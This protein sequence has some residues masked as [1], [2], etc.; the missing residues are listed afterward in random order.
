MLFQVLIRIQ[1]SRTKKQDIR[2]GEY[3]A[4]QS[5][6]DKVTGYVKPNKGT[7]YKRLNKLIDT[8]RMEYLEQASKDASDSQSMVKSKDDILV[9][10]E[11]MINNLDKEGKENSR[12]LFFNVKNHIVEVLY[13]TDRPLKL[14]LEDID[15]IFLD[16]FKIHLVSKGLAVSTIKGYMDKITTIF[17][18]INKRQKHLILNPIKDYKRKIKNVETKISFHSDTFYQ[19][20]YYLPKSKERIHYKNWN[21][22][23][24]FSQ[25]QRISDIIITDWTSISFVN[26]NVKDSMKNKGKVEKNKVRYHFNAFKTGTEHDM[27]LCNQAILALRFY[28]DRDLQLQYLVDSENGIDED[29]ELQYYMKLIELPSER[30]LHGLGDIQD[31][32]DVLIPLI[33]IQKLRTPKKCIFHDVYTEKLTH[34]EKVK[35]ITNKSTCLSKCQLANEKDEDY[36]AKDHLSSHKFRHLFSSHFYEAKKN[37]YALS[38]LLFHTNINTTSRYLATLDVK[39][40]ED[41]IKDFYENEIH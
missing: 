9:E 27:I 7:D 35:L 5:D 39:I 15:D 18:N 24:Y 20:K 32:V 31:K 34:K 41:D 3:V 19:F 4:N 30:R 28:L 21:I 33:K 29:T 1:K 8:L 6:F 2:T 17:S 10:F 40:V 11:R 16:D 37:I 13:A 25:G 38:L 14:E 12:R 23:Q 36:K 26:S 22:F